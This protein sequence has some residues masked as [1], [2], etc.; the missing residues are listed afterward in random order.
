MSSAC[1]NQES[2]I[3]SIQTSDLNKDLIGHAGIVFKHISVGGENMLGERLQ[4]AI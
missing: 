3:V 4:A 2:P 1:S